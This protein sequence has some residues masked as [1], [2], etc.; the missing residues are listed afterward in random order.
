MRDPSADQT[1]AAAFDALRV[2][3][4]RNEAKAATRLDPDT[5]A[6]ARA[7]RWLERL[8]AASACRRQE[9]G[10]FVAIIGRLPAPYAS[11]HGE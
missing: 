7:D 9:D 3:K 2:R 10:R 1:A 8:Q 6:T 5:E 4:E 11:I